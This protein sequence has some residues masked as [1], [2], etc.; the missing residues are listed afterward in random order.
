M[1]KQQGMTFIGM[2]LAMMGVVITGL[3]V[4]QIIPVYIQNYS[5]KQS[6]RSLNQTPASDLTGDP[7]TD[8]GILK[9]TLDKR[10]DINGISNIKEDQVK[11]IPSGD[12]KYTVKLKYQVVT[13]LV[14]H[15]NL[16][17]DFDETYE[18]EAKSAR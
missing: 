7:I 16:M 11:F 6:I 5:I 1:K 18:V 2:L 10:L 12:K 15:A 14:F 17:F 9:S 8:I 3:L 13:P 4:V